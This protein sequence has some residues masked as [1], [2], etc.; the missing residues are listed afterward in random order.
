MPAREGDDGKGGRD[1]Q[2]PSWGLFEEAP[3]RM[4]GGIDQ[5]GVYLIAYLTWEG[6]EVLEAL[7]VGFGVLSESDTARGGDGL[8][9]EFFGFPHIGIAGVVVRR[10]GG[11][12]GERLV[13]VEVY[14][15]RNP[16]R[17]QR[18]PDL[19]VRLRWGKF[20]RGRGWLA[21]SCS[22][23]TCRNSRDSTKSRLCF[24]W[25]PWDPVLGETKANVY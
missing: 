16:H 24:S 13:Y 19:L 7:H 20:T 5:K 6:K 14:R 3:G 12:E 8:Q 9:S 2:V 18:Q 23:N 21:T 17:H 25:G 11:G 22:R 1:R 4:Q 10:F 15:V